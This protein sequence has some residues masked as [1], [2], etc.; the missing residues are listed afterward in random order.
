MEKTL[1][2]FLLQIPQTIFNLT[3][4]LV[5]PISE[6]YLNISPLGLLSVGGTAILITLVV[7]HVVKLFI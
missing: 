5:K 7:V 4:W 6:K 3:S 1:F 2:E